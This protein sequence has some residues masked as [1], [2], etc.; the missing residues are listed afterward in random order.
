MSLQTSIATEPAPIIRYALLFAAFH[1]PFTIA[2]GYIATS[3]NPHPGSG[4]GIV[5][6]YAAAYFV[7]WRFA[8]R[9]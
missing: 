2:M 6:I 3:I 5:S 7:G 1:F 8:A 4:L 9:R